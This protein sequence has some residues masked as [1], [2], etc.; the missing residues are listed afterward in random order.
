MPPSTQTFKPRSPR[1]AR[2]A[3]LPLRRAGH[4]R[5]LRHRA[6]ARAAGARSRREVERL[7]A[8]Y[9]RA[10][11]GHG[12]RVG[13]L[14]E[15]RP[16]FFAPLAR[17]ERARRQHRADQRRHALGRAGVPDRPQRDRARGRRCPG[18]RATCAPPRARPARCCETIR[19]E[20]AGRIAVARC[21]G[22]R[23]AAQPIGRDTECAL[24]YTSGTTGRPKGCLL[25]NGYFLRAGELVPRPRRAGDVRPDVERFIT[26]L[27]L[28][29]MNALAFS[30]MAVIL[31]RRLPRPARPLPSADLV[32]ERA[33][34][35]RDDRPLPRRDAGDAARGAAGARPTASTA[36]ASAS[37]P[38][39]TRAT[40]R[41]RG[42]LRL[43]AA[44]GL[45]DDRD[46]RRRPASSPT[47]SRAT[48][49]PAASAAPSRSSRRAS[50]TTKGADVARR[51][52]RRA[53][54]A[55]RRRR[56]A[57]RLLPRL[58]EGRDGDRGGLG[59]RL[60]PHRRRREARR[61]EGTSTSSTARR[62]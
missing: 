58:P 27:P 13:L 22:A 26:P 12:H 3:R 47:A 40:T 55:R 62:T 2:D 8:A 30:S 14:L 39:S 6:R 5:S 48:S 29:H 49:A 10:G 15:N 60:V 20:V 54:G 31:V 51:H 28:S 33:R 1:A 9:A 7:R 56:P 38:A 44:R 17:A 41:L 57:R 42:A 4:G 21:A 37:A 32:A 46:R 45:G 59:R 11:Y 50:S 18:A 23:R 34:E 61:A 36:C 52:A 53:A 35:R 43:S 19:P 25:A 16:A 24:L